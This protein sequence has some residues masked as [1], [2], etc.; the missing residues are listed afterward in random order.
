VPD[1]HGTFD[2]RLE[3]YMI[4]YAKVR[5]IYSEILNGNLLQEPRRTFRQIYAAPSER[6]PDIKV[7]DFIFWSAG[8]LSFVAKEI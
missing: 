1:N 7:L 8:K 5:D 2:L 3:K 4:F 6:I